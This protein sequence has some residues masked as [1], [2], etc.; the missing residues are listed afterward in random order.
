MDQRITQ[1]QQ[2]LEALQRVLRLS[3]DAAMFCNQLEKNMTQITTHYQG[4]LLV[5]KNWTD[6]F[7][8]SSLVDIPPTVTQAEEESPEEIVRIAV[9]NSAAN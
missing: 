3:R 5:A 6:A 7:A 4:K 1:K 9:G 8:A 2:E